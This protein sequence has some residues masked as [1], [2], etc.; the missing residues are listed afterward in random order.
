MNYINMINLNQYNSVIFDFDGVILESNFVKKS[1][2]GQAVEGVL[3]VEKAQEFVDYFVGLNG[4]P[5]EVKIA[6][7]VPQAQYEYVLN[8]YESIIEKELKSAQLIPG[9]VDTI[10]QLSKLKKGM[11]VLSGGTQSEVEELLLERG[12]LHHF[13]AVLGGPKNKTENLATVALKRPVLYFGDSRVDYQVAMDN[14]FDFV[15]VYG[16]SNIENW[17]DQAKQWQVSGVIENFENKGE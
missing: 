4:V 10:Q 17:Q 9:V 16:A 13:S 11:I 7:Y 8:K 5:R 12:L 15:F 6:K 1:A 14:D 2:I 3:S